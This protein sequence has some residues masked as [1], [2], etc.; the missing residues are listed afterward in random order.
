MLQIPEQIIWLALEQI[1]IIGKKEGL[2][3]LFSRKSATSIELQLTNNSNVSYLFLPNQLYTIVNDEL[4][5]LTKLTSVI[6][7]RETKI[8][9][10]TSVSPIHLLLDIDKRYRL[11]IHDIN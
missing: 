10:V 5:Y 8:I 1:Q 2:T 3:V 4:S 6:S 7:V 11:I 9:L